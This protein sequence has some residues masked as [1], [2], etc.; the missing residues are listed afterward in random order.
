MNDTVMKTATE[1]LE[2]DHVYIIRLTEVMQK[3][4]GVGSP[5]PS[6]I[7]S[8]IAIIRNFADG[9]HHAKEE[10]LLF[11]KLGEKGL[12]PN[13][14]P[15]AVMLH[16][17]TEGRNF[18]KGMA[19][20]LS[21]YRN[22]NLEAAKEIS[23]NLAGYASLLHD[24]IAKENNILFR[25]ADNVLSAQEQSDLLLDFE[26][27]EANLEEGKRPEDYIKKIGELEAIYL[28]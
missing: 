3:M 2:N 22:G 27:V 19:E 9:I 13:Q 12:S 26:K 8:V 18:V 23:I 11:P 5:D 21:L 4:A 28:K 25:M 14:G 10:N 24:H 1:N 7:E 15:V 17:H 6:H 20:N 16:E